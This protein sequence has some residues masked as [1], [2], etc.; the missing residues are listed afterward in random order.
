MWISVR[1]SPGA[2]AVVKRPWKK[3]STLDGALAVRA[4]RHHVGSQSQHRR[5][6]VVGRIAVGEVAADGGAVPDQRVGDHLGGVQQDRIAGRDDRAPLSSADLRHQRADAQEAAVLA[7][8]VKARNAADVHDVRRRRQPQLEHRQQALAARH[9]LGV[10]ELA[11]QR[12][13]LVE[14]AGGMIV[15]LRGNHSS[16]FTGRAP[17]PG[18]R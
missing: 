9:D 11:E 1:I 5:R 16:S 2:S 8:R 3:S 14:A 13:R 18:P 17:W 7:D 4:G 6:V 12:E 10:V 15:E